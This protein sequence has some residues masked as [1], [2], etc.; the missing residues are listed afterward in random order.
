MVG[1]RLWPKPGTAFG[2]TVLIAGV[3]LSGVGC[4]VKIWAFEVPPPGAGLLTVKLPLPAKARSPPCKVTSSWLLLTNLVVRAVPFHCAWTDSRKFW[5]RRVT[6]KPLLP[7]PCSTIVVG[8]MLLSEGAGFWPASSTVKITALEVPPP[9]AG[10]WTVTPAGWLS[11]TA[12]AL[13]RS[14]SCAAKAA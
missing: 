14:E 10:F 2:L 12:A 5:P 1:D 3:G 7:A 13:I 11:S 9:G 6:V 8:S 4:I